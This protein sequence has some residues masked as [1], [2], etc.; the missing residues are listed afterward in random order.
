MF[1]ISL[2]YFLGLQVAKGKEK[3]VE[4]RSTDKA[5]GGVQLRGDSEKPQEPR[6]PRRG[7]KI[8]GVRETRTKGLLV[9]VKCAAKDRGRLDSPSAP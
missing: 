3:E 8:G 2:E 9:K 4:A 1:L 5:Y 6:K 7:V